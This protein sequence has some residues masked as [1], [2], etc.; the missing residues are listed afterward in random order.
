VKENIERIELKG[1]LSEFR[2][3]LE[4]EIDAIKNGG[5]SSTLL[6]A[7]QQLESHSMDFWYRFRVEYMPSLPADTPC[8]LLIGKEQFDV[9]VI[10]CEEDNIIISSKVF[11]PNTLGKVRLENGATVLMERLI[12]CIEKNAE[13]ENPV[14]KR[15]ISLGG[16]V[17]SAQCIASHNNLILSE[18][19]TKSQRNAIKSALTNDITYIWGPPGTGKTS[20][21]GQIIDELYKQNR[22]VLIVSHTNVA[23]DGAIEKAYITYDAT[24]P[25]DNSAYPIL[26]IGNHANNLPDKV[27]MKNHVA[28]L[29]KELVY[30]K[31][32][33]E[34]QQ[35]EA[36]HRINEILPLIAKCAWIR[37]SKLDEIRDM[38]HTVTKHTKSIQEIQCEIDKINAAIQQ[39]RTEHPEAARYLVLSKTIKAKRSEYDNAY[40]QRYDKES[41]IDALEQKILYVQDEIKKHDIYAD[42]CAKEA[43][44]MS[45][46]FYQNE[47]D[48]LQKEMVADSQII[49][50]MET[51][52]NLAQQTIDEY[53]K[54]SAVAKLLFRKS[55]V[56]QAQ[57]TL[58]DIP[59]QLAQAKEKLQQQDAL[60]Q[61][62]QRQ[63][64]SLLVL[65]KQIKAVIPSKTQTYW[66]HE[67]EQCHAQLTTTIEDI[68]SL[69]MQI[70]AFLQE[71]YS[72]EEQ[73][74]L[75][76]KSFDALSKYGTQ[77]KQ[78]QKQLEEHKTSYIQEKLHCAEYLKKETIF[79][80]AFSYIPSA[81]DNSALFDELSKLYSY[82]Q[83][84]TTSI[85]EEVL[86]QEKEYA[87]K[88]LK[89]IA[90]QLNEVKQKM[91]ELEKQ[92]IMNA[93]IIGTTLAISYL[94]ETLRARKF[95]TVI[96]D[97]A[98]MASIPALWC[99][100]YLAEN[101][102][103]IVGDFLQLPPIVIAKPDFDEQNKKP[104]MAQEWLGKD[105]F[106]HS[107]MQEL[108][109]D[110]DTC[111][112]NF[113]M[114]NDQFRMESDIA[115][116]A[117]M[118]YGEYGGLISRDML[119]SRISKR[120]EFYKWY[121]GE[122]TE[123]HVHLID[124]ESLHA[125]VTGV[126]Q[127]KSH[128]R[129]NAFSA[130]VCVDLAFKFIENKLNALDPATAKPVQE[131]SVLIVAPYK[132]HIKRINQLIELEYCNRGFKEKNLNYIKAGTIHSFQGSEADIVLF[133][134]VIDEPHWNANLFRT[135]P[136]INNDLRKMF[137]VAI[138]RARFKL[139]IVGNFAYCQKRAKNNALSELLDFLLTKKQL[140]K[141]D[142]KAVLPDIVFSRPTSFAFNG[143]ITD[144]HIVCVESAFNDY[145]MAD[146]QI[147]KKR[148]IIYSPFMSESRL[149]MLRPAFE[150][151]INAGKQII[152][153]TKALSERKKTE[154]AH[155][156]KCEQGL[157]DIG[158]SILHKK[159]MH[160]KT[161]FVDDEAVWNGSLNA[162][163]FTGLTGEIM[164]R[165]AGRELVEEF[166]KLLG[167][168]N[169]NQAI[170]NTY[171]QRCPIC[172]DEML[173]RESDKGGIYWQCTNKDYSRNAA[174]PYPVDGILRCSK[175]G[176]PYQFDMKKE[177]RWV[178]TENAKHYQKMRKSD[179]QLEKMAAL[180]PSKTSRK[181]VDKYFEEH[182][183][184]KRKKTRTTQESDIQ[185]KT[186][187][188]GQLELF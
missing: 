130:T 118:Y 114:L 137:N 62:Y 164:E 108:A 103:V 93:K 100:S 143:E 67:L 163:S 92:A 125:W 53:E 169:L 54:K 128:S 13:V 115:E 127:G 120:N 77:L 159:G 174:Q 44:L 179:L 166:E 107:G 50:D 83:S 2:T 122:Q 51:R 71:L 148:L 138:T 119:E 52:L 61:E 72:L 22:S 80:A 57:T 36:Q 147:F 76:K 42:L 154:L 15:M 3:A 187:I 106:Y 30:Q 173:I 184:T 105:I 78:K 29:G 180:I 82:V 14:G 27:S 161:I 33:L 170:E 18:E 89:D 20:V 110:K 6:Y 94:N 5:L 49:S 16:G 66:Q 68:S 188:Y 75:A 141:V 111:P 21:I 168:E 142:A 133:D 136:E 151:A 10:S 59:L 158:V 113:V 79:C 183:K 1:F 65:Q 156:Q 74:R 48:K 160:E 139:F 181:E 155:Y 7:G 56:T 23:V 8:K 73:Q 152:V 70:D 95:D 26:R 87:D 185:H 131:A 12:D 116:I 117:D 124:T 4:E 11:L 64:K 28:R 121:S 182:S 149:S 32:F 123:E 47:L 177:P 55:N 171:E 9:T 38:L 109:K 146:I 102:I 98:S 157:R 186:D 101:N 134:L 172:G 85:K 39:E 43:K 165:H 40:E 41:I 97:E 19:K 140:P 99:A 34:Q 175:C 45:V 162:L 144:K 60:E 46:S 24:N 25:D 126:P 167:I 63:L 135:E 88:Q 81:E 90:Q 150:D 69:N 84:E 176:A 35:I 86:L 129:L 112:H 58:Q 96:L 153:V 104:S 31:D 132:P 145:F 91:Q 178:C 17:Y 37:E